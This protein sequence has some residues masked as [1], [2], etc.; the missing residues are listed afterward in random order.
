MIK[1]K[2]IIADTPYF[3]AI[4]YFNTMKQYTKQ[5]PLPETKIYD[6]IEELR[7]G[8]NNSSINYFNEVDSE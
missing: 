7:I 8:L 5:N 3:K 6:S 1:R 2:S 4:V